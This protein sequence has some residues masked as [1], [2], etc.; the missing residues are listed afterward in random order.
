MNLKENDGSQDL[1][2]GNEGDN[3]F[4]EGLLRELCKTLRTLIP[5]ND[6]GIEEHTLM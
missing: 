4:S 5:R 3:F 1:L 6:A 2:N